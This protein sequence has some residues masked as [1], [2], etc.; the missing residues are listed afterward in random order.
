MTQFNYR[1]GMDDREVVA[2][3]AA[4][5]PA[6]IAVGYDRYAPH[7]Y[8][9]CRWMLGQP[10]EAAEAVKNTFVITSA[11]LGDFPEVLK[12]RPWLY[13][14]ARNECLR[15]LR[16]K[17]PGGR[18]EVDAAGQSAK[19]A[20]EVGD[21]PRQTELRTLI[22]GILAELKPREREVIELSLI[23]HLNDADLAATLGMSWSRAHALATR[24]QGRLEKALDTLLITRTGRGACPVLDK[25]LLDREGQLAEQTRVLVGGHIEQCE[26]CGDRKRGALRPAALAGL[27]SQ[28]ATLPSGLR[29]QVLELCSS[30]SRDAV[31]YRRRLARRAESMWPSR[32]SQ[33]MWLIRPGSIRIR[34]R[35]ATA[36]LALVVWVVA[37]WAAGLTLL[38]FAGPHPS[39]LLA[40]RS[41]VRP[42]PSRTASSAATTAPTLTPTRSASEA[43]KPSP[44]VSPSLTYIPPPV[45]PSASPTVRPTPSK[46]PSA[47]P[48]KSPSAKPSKS[49]SPSPSS[50]R[51]PSS[52]PSTAA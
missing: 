1:V 39:P 26:I 15:R 12:L 16:Q 50:S 19:E 32:F 44:S 40:T 25:L 52:A 34:P 30:T 13:A 45:L 46:S 6:G 23:H 14:M 20:A 3:I 5:D 18:D 47:K 31:A 7:L 43:A 37:V 29:G 27:L 11:T 51:S 38:I 4:R 21:D 33:A 49:P 24:A 8:G 42:L 10:A 22:R 36:N 35:A 17:T 41:A 28:A 48:S 2:A 9:Y